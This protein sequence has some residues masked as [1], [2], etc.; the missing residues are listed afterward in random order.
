RRATRPLDRAERP[1]RGRARRL[2]GLGCGLRAPGGGLEP[3]RLRRDARRGD[4]GA[5]QV[6]GG[7]SRADRG[8]RADRRVARPRGGRRPRTRLRAPNLH[9]PDRAS[10]APFTARARGGVLAMNGAPR[11]PSPTEAVIWHDVECGAYDGD[12]RLWEELAAVH[13]DPI[14]ELG[15][16]TG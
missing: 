8:T 13:G 1:H 10:P 6:R 2:L 15:A 14:L 11:A 3:R 9:G 7:R 16:G 4:G 5:P 12:L